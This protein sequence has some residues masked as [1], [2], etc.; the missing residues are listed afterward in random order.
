MVFRTSGF[1]GLAVLSTV[2]AVVAV[3]SGQTSPTSAPRRPG[4]QQPARDTPAQRDDPSSP[5]G[6]IA[7]RVLAADTGRPVK[8]ARVSISANEL[9]G[10]RGVLTDDAGMFQAIDLP[11]G[12]YTLSVSK[13]GFVSLAYGQRRPLQAGTPIQLAEGQEIRDIE[14]R[15]PRGSVIAGHVYDETGDAMPGVV[16]RVLRYQ[17]QQGNRRLMT[18]GTAQTDDLGQYRVWGLMP[19]DYYVDAQSRINLP[20]GGPAGGGRGRGGP[21]PG[22]IAGLVGAIAGPNVGNLFAP[23]D[24]NQKAYAPTY[25]PGVPSIDEA[26]AVTVGLGQTASA[27]DFALQLVRV[28]RLSGRVLNPDGSVTTRG[29]VNLTTETQVQGRGNQLGANYGSRISGDGTF[30]ITNV[31]PGRYVLRARGNNA[32]WPQ[33]ASMPVTVAG[34]DIS[35]LSITVAEGATILGTVSFPPTG[36]ELPNLRQVRISSVAVD[37]AL[38]NSLARIEEDNSFKIVAIPAG[39]HLIRPSGPLR[40]W[41][42]KSVVLDG[43][44]ITDTPIEV[45]GGQEIR[46]VTVTFTDAV[47]EINGTITTGQG[48]PI[49][50]YTVLA[51]STDS[52]FWRPLS[53]HIATAR[54]DQ[55]GRFTIR[56]LP[57]GGYYLAAVDPAQQG[58]WYAP[59]YLEEHRFGAA[60]VTLNEG[61][62]KTQDFKVRSQN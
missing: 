36:G 17:Y 19:G 5:S 56:G 51:F 28:A 1:R 41:S 14:V 22:A 16:V 12:R 40:G 11:A 27:I 18:A 47:N 43:R 9:P 59:S 62:T 7:G 50:E 29:N 23:E 2:V 55:T 38:A 44:D 48:T 57:A 24:E 21:A 10:G 30:T 52:T 60:Q 58:E 45:R 49:T 34:A 35:D 13:S 6:L 32:D 61:E 26:Q 31:P 33:Y 46:R 20:F 37:P 15:L 4:P 8:R 42:L 39:A 53:R 25:F 3:V 54:P